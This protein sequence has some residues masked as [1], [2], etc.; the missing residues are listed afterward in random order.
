MKYSEFSRKEIDA[1]CTLYE[2]SKLS[3]EEEN[4]L[5]I[6][7]NQRRDLS[8]EAVKTLRLMRVERS[9]VAKNK[10]GA[11]PWIKKWAVAAAAAV[12]VAVSVPYLISTG[13]SPDE[14][15]YVVWQNGKK[16]TGEKAKKMVEESQKIDMEMLRKAMREQ[17]EMMRGTYAATDTEF[18]N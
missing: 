6:L 14:A 8:P 3:L 7:L 11:K 16:I 13:D 1:L 5:Y 17:R 4:S 15:Y 18:F 12:L 10:S 2:E 9:V